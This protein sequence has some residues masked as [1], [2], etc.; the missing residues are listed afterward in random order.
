M[1]KPDRELIAQVML[2]SQGFRSAEILASKVVPFFNLCQEQLTSQSHYDF[3]LR[4]LKSVLVSAGNLKREKLSDLRQSLVGGAEAGQ[5]ENALQ[6]M[7][8]T[9]PEQEILIQSIRETVLPKLVSDDINL[10][11]RYWLTVCLR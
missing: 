7:S 11:K 8:N 4:S 9:I 1:T 6:Q 2:Y 3:G 5:Y 10:L